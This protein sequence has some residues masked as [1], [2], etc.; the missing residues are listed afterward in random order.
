M[1]NLLAM[2]FEGELA[3]SFDLRCLE[4]GRK[5]PDGWGI[6]YYPGG[7]PCAPVLKEPVPL[8]GSIRSELIKAWDHLAASLFLLHIRSATWGQI[9]DA[10]TQPFSRTLGGRDWL[11]AHAGSLHSKLDLGDSPRYEPV[12]STDT[13]RVFCRLLGQIAASGARRLGDVPATVLR[14]WLEDINTYGALTLAL[15][16]GDDL[17]VYADRDGAG[18]L[19]LWEIIPPYETAVFGDDDL[20]VDL[21]KRGITSKRGVIVSSSQLDAKTE[22]PVTW[23]KLPPG[24]LV[25]IR[26]GAIRVETSREPKAPSP[27][28]ASAPRIAVARGRPEPRI[29]DVHHRTAYTYQRQ[30]ER[31]THRLRLTPTHDRLQTLHSHEITVSVDGEGFD[32]DD[33]FGNRVR[34]LLLDTPYTELVIEA[35]SRVEVLDTDPLS[36][37]PRRSQSTMPVVWMPWQRQILQPFLLPPELPESQLE[38]LVAYASSFKERNDSDLFDTLVDMNDTIFREYKYQQNTTTLGTTA[39]DVFV[40]RRGVCQDFANLFICLARLMSVPARYAYG[41]VYTGP[42]HANQVQGEASHAW[43]QV[44]LPQLGWRGFD[45]TNGS[46]VQT[47][48]VRVAVGRN[49][50]DAT[51]T[52]GTI[53]V[54]GGPERMSVDV[55]VKISDR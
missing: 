32:Y 38:E 45:P 28:R 50:V 42:K 25:I 15:T 44:Y 19:Y 48:H 46:I 31:S 1:P 51:P 54:G 24:Q 8:H 23:R 9:S 26:K 36:F 29:Y 2:S 53:Y 4:R 20:S 52:S 6:G 55:S 33:V 39:W 7:E 11:C 16:D 12:G 49:Y 47:D 14:G 10:N 35:K 17:V 13:E 37:H 40:N 3:P 43:V 21:T 30:V 22:A 41:Y 34:H 18:D 27:V 5:H